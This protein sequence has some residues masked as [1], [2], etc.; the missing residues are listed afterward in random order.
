MDAAGG[1]HDPLGDCRCLPLPFC[2][3][4]SWVFGHLVFLFLAVS[5]VL[6]FTAIIAG[7]LL[8]CWSF[9]WFS[10]LGVL[11]V[12]RAAVVC[13]VSSPGEER[14]RRK[15]SS[16][17]DSEESDKSNSSLSS[18]ASEGQVFRMATGIAQKDSQ[19]RL[20]GWAKRHPGKLASMQL[21][22]MDGKIG[23][24]WIVL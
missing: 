3:C 16:S 20:I 18:G 22:R 9:V 23:I 19:L 4:L 24:M 6:A 15:S 2:S 1:A 8:V 21:L 14:K 11:A 13:K 7:S 12:V 5:W 17:D 10:L